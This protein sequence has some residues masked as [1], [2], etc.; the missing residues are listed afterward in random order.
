M[1]RLSVPLFAHLRYP[2]WFFSNFSPLVLP[3][4]PTSTDGDIPAELRL[5]LAIVGQIKWRS[6][7]GGSKKYRGLE[8][9]CVAR[10]E[11]R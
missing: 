2:P 7:N 1:L 4:G 6:K 9:E 10:G 11:I 8:R 3:F 5:L